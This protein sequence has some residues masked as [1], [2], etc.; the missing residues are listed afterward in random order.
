MARKITLEGAK[1]IFT[2]VN[3]QELRMNET[4]V[5]Y[6]AVFGDLILEDAL[7]RELCRRLWEVTAEAAKTF[8]Y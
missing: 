6:R 4:V 3:F 5:G 1:A 2:E 7:L 8:Q